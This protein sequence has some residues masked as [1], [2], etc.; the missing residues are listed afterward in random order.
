M[1]RGRMLNNSISRSLK[2]DQLPDDT[3]RLLATWLISH[4]DKNGVFYGDPVMIKSLI[5]PRRGDVTIEQVET[6]L[7]AMQDVGLI[8]LFEAEG[9][10]WQYWPG[11]TDNQIGLRADREAT[12]FPLPPTEDDIPEPALEPT[13]EPD[14][15]NFPEQIPDT[16]PESIRQVS[17]TQPESIPPNIN[18]NRSLNLNTT[19]TNA[20]VENSDSENLALITEIYQNQIAATFSSVMADEFKEYARRCRSPDWIIHAFKQAEINNVRKWSYVR[21]V[22]DDCIV[23]DCIVEKGRSR[24]EIHRNQSTSNSR[25]PN[26]EKRQNGAE[27]SSAAKAKLKRLSK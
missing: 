24:N 11:F 8:I 17:G 19:T 23:N 5:F 3:S 21:A 9:Q 6:Y 12:D 18:L 1:A 7:Q 16:Q 20:R 14:N 10:L 4:L 13:P 26:D 27:F 22:L 2:F 25:Y 15:G